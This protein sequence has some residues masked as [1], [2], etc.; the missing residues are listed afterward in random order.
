MRLVDKRTRVSRRLFLRG[1]AAALPAAA[2]AAAG[3]SITAQSAWAQDAKSLP[4]HV[5]ASLVKMARDIYPHDHIGDSFYVAAVQPWDD[6]AGADPAFR[7]LMIEGVARLDSDA[8]DSHGADYLSVAWE[9]DRVVLLQ[10]IAQTPF[11][12]KARSDLV[13]SLYN[14]Q[15]LWPK[16]GYEGPSAEHGGYIHRGFD[17]IDWLPSA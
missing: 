1:T 9:A 3:L 2:V 15:A 17:D 12:K 7:V 4:P 6:K 5:M 10:G 16:L 14:Q 13:V 8:K 11:F